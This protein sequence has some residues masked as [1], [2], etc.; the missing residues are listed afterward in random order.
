MDNDLDCMVDCKCGRY[1]HLKSEDKCGTCESEEQFPHFDVGKYAE[2]LSKMT[3][4]ELA[5]EDVS[6]DVRKL[7]CIIMEWGRRGYRNH[8]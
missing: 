2:K 5:S 3:L 7:N 8:F 4:S 1:L 6:I